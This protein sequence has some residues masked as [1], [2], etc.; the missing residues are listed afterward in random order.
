MNK[1]KMKEINQVIISVDETGKR[2]VVIPKIIFKGKRSI[3]WREVEK[4]LLGSSIVKIKEV[5]QLK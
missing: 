5:G 1:R 3:D 2:I 4:Y